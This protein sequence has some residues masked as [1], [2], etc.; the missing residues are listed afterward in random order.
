MR[1][2][3]G[4]LSRLHTAIE[5]LGAILNNATGTDEV[6]ASPTYQANVCA[7]LQVALH[8]L[9]PLVAWLILDSYDE[10]VA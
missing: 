8:R 4:R 10:V 6:E 1:L 7:A 9:P 2:W 3:G 5:D